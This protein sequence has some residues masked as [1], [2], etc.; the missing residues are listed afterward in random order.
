MY[1]YRYMY[2]YIKPTA[3]YTIRLRSDYDPTVQSGHSR[4]VAPPTHYDLT[5]TA[6]RRAFKGRTRT[7]FIDVTNSLKIMARASSIF[8]HFVKHM[9][10]E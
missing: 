3:H 5:Q 1:K 10:G 4:I 8:D 6:Q 2:W 9:E 7:K